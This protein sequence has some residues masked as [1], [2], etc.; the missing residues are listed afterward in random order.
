MVGQVGDEQVLAVVLQRL[1]DQNP[2]PEVLSSL[3]S[4]PSPSP[5]PSPF[6]LSLS[7]SLSHKKAK[8]VVGARIRRGVLVI[9]GG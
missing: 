3:L 8:R 2:L 1:L 5:S 7:L 9:G 6:S 4:S